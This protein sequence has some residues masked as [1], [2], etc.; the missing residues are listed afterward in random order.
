M[1]RLLPVAMTLALLG[2]PACQRQVSK[3]S[4]PAVSGSQVLAEGKAASPFTLTLSSGGGFAGLYQGCTLTSQGEVKGWQKRAG[5]PEAITWAVQVRP[6][7]IAA[8]ARE[9]EAYLRVELQDAG[10]M[11]TRILLKLPD[12]THQ[13]SIS[14]SGSSAEAPEPFRTWYARAE[15]YCR[16]LAPP[17]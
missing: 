9:L 15:A 12:T 13:W 1:P 11:T 7:S 17:P 3:S 4:K 2:I 10:N 6:D 5:A 8:F 14:G 16:S